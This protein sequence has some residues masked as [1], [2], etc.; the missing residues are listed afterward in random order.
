M[1]GVRK[2]FKVPRRVTKKDKQQD[3]KINMLMTLAKQEVKYRDEYQQGTTSTT[4][5]INSL[6][7][8]I[9][10]GTTNL[11]RIG[12]NISVTNVYVR[13]VLANVLGDL[14]NRM[15]VIMFIDQE[16]IGAPTAAGVTGVLDGAAG[17]YIPDAPIHENNKKRYRILYDRYFLIDNKTTTQN[18]NVPFVIKK[19]FKK[20]LNITYNQGATTVLKNELYIMIVSDSAILD[21]SYDYTSRV[22]FI[23]S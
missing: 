18:T 5:Y 19:K 12:N 7:A 15:R 17:G 1:V 11:D 8:G 2:R 6:V 10:T 9:A 3:K 21:P 13:G 14:Y 4:A 16:A 20:P 23:D 22:S